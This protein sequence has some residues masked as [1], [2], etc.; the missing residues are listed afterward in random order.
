MLLC[1]QNL[2]NTVSQA[3]QSA[4]LFT[5]TLNH[6]QLKIFNNFQTTNDKAKNS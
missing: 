1:F 3:F 4:S 2:Q 6:F 5:G